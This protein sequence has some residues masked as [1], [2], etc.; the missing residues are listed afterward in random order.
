MSSP[1]NPNPTTPPHFTH[2]STTNLLHY[3]PPPLH[4]SSTTLVR[5]SRDNFYDRKGTL[6]STWMNQI[7]LHSKSKIF[8][9]VAGNHDYWGFGTPLLGLKEDQVREREG[10]EAVFSVANHPR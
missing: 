5:P 3:T 10:K 4:T 1:C 7:N 6:T 8:A 9:T 2:T